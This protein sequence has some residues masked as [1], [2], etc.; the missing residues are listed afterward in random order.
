MSNTTITFLLSTIILLMNVTIETAHH[1]AKKILCNDWVWLKMC[2][3]HSR[4]D[5]R[6]NIIPKCDT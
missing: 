6:H 4:C 2:G 1:D 3:N 5:Q